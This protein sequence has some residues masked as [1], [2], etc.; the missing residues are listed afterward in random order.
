MV[1]F[2][3]HQDMDF[4]FL[5][6]FSTDFEPLLPLGL[7]LIS[8]TG[9]CQSYRGRIAAKFKLHIL[10]F[11]SL[12]LILCSSSSVLLQNSRSWVS[13]PDLI[14]L[15]ELG[16]D[17][18]NW[19]EECFFG[20]IATCLKQSWSTTQCDQNPYYLELWGSF[21]PSRMKNWICKLAVAILCGKIEHRPTTAATSL[22]HSLWSN[23]PR[24]GRDCLITNSFPTC[25]LLAPI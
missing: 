22:N 15:W 16:Y 1:G 18:C 21:C 5:H 2:I 13:L 7:C 9:L 10:L 25:C 20:P 19:N 3:F 12:N 14:G 23:W 17:W 4:S 8:Q 6:D 24:M 11:F